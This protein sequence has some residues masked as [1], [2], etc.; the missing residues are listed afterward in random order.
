MSALHRYRSEVENTGALVRGGS[1][2]QDTSESQSSPAMYLE[3]PSGEA[4]WVR[5]HAFLFCLRLARSQM[6]GPKRAIEGSIPGVNEGR[7]IP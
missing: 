5:L 2:S 6:K 7:R 4:G 3:F 1:G